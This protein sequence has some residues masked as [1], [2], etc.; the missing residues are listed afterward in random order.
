MMHFSRRDM[1]KHSFCLGAAALAAGPFGRALTLAQAT[2]PGSKMKYGLVTYL[3]AKDW[4]LPTLIANCE[5]SKVLGV[6]L[7]TEHAHGVGPSMNAQQRAEVKKRFAD[8]PVE[9]VGLGTNECYDSPDP[10]KL[11]TCI[12]NTKAFIKLGQDVGASGVKVKP[13]DLHEKDGVPREKTIEQISK[14]LNEL[15]AFAA[16]YG[17]QLRLEV[18]GSCCELPIMKAII[19]G[20][21]NKNVGLCWNSNDKDLEGDGLE[22]NFNLVKDRLGATTHVREFNLGN[23]PYP[24]LIRLFVQMDYA[25]W[26]LLE[27]RETPEKPVEA[28]IEQRELFEKLVGQA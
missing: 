9:L 7:R 15:G 14:S 2:K 6:E 16:D 18:H 23:Y 8:S 28:L 13:N 4:D 19:D 25:G 3:W 24:E 27:G 11:Q 20:V 1:L 26:I 10:A 21:E 22:A 17:Q 12:E 5:Q